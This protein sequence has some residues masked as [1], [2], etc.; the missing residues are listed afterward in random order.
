MANIVLNTIGVLGFILWV[1]FN[2][3]VAITYTTKQ[4]VE[5]FVYNQCMV[6][7]FLAFIY[8]IPAWIIK[9]FKFAIVKVVK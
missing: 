6:G 9:L 3:V 5:D 7:K 1:I 4:M 8:F 2:V